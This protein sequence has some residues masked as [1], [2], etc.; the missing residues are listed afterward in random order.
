[1]RDIILFG[2]QGSGKGTQGKILAEKFNLDVFEAGAELRALANSSS[3][4][5][6]KVR[7]I[8]NSG[9]LVSDEI[10]MDVIENFLRN[11]PREQSVI[12]DGIPRRLSQQKLFD[13]L[14]ERLGRNPIAIYIE[15][16]DDEVFK[17]LNNRKICEKCKA[18]CIDNPEDGV[19]P[20][21][22][23]NGKLVQREDDS[24]AESIQTRIDLYKSETL[25]VIK[26]Y[27][28]EDRVIKINGEQSIEE[29]NQ[30]ILTSLSSLV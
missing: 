15:I 16:S 2:I 17:R 18:V 23:C 14:M 13:N 25:A 12:F 6:Q 3:P 7:E 4:L 24:N 10:I 21:E 27:T 30:E 1:M 8:I 5:G 26:E 20:K 11:V 19:C 28:N 29:V 9:Q 22:D